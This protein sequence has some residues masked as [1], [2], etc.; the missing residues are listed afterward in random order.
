[1][2]LSDY[3]LYCSTIDKPNENLS[4]KHVHG[5]DEVFFDLIFTTSLIYKPNGVDSIWVPLERIYWFN[6]ASVVDNNASDYWTIISCSNNIE[7]DNM[8]PLQE[9]SDNVKYYLNW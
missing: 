6:R 2:H 1:M 5:Y 7:Q 3:V 9:W 8:M 4:Y